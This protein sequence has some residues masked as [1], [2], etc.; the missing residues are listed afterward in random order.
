MNGA[1][2]YSF[3]NNGY[4]VSNGSAVTISG[5]SIL[6]KVSF[7]IQLVN[8]SPVN[9]KYRLHI[10]VTSGNALFSL[11]NFRLTG[12]EKVISVDGKSDL[13]REYLYEK[14][15]TITVNN[16]TVEAVTFNY[17]GIKNY[18]SQWVA[19]D[20]SESEQTEQVQVEIEMPTSVTNDL[21]QSDLFSQSV[22]IAFT[23]EAVTGNSTTSAEY[24]EWYQSDG[25]NKID[26]VAS[27]DD[28]Y[29]KTVVGANNSRTAYTEVIIPCAIYNVDKGKYLP[30]TTI[31]NTTF[32]YSE[33]R[34]EWWATNL[35]TIVVPASLKD[36]A[37]AKF[38]HCTSLKNI[39]ISDLNKNF[40]MDNG[41][42]FNTLINP[43]T[44]YCYLPTKTDTSYV[45][46]D[47]ITKV[48]SAAFGSNQY[49]TSI[50]LGSNVT[51]I[52]YGAF[53]EI[54]TLEEF[55]IPSDSQ[56]TQILSYCFSGDE[57][58]KEFSMPNTVTTLQ[59]NAF[60]GC[61]ALESIILSS[62]LTQLLDD[63]FSGCAS[64][65]SIYF[66]NTNEIS[67]TTETSKIT[68]IGNS[69]F[70]NCTSL[71]NITIP[72]K[73]TSI[74][75]VVFAN[76]QELTKVTFQGEV[77]TIGGYAFKNCY[78][79]AN[80]TIP[81]TVS[82][83]NEYTF[84]SCKSLTNITIP[85]KVTSI[86]TYAFK[87]CTGLTEIAIPA[88]VTSIGKDAF[89]SCS[90]LEYIYY[91]G[92]ESAWKEAVKGIDKDSIEQINYANV[93]TNCIVYVDYKSE[94]IKGTPYK[95]DTENGWVAVTT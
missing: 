56:L 18:Y 80:I 62:G 78:K 36:F 9:L 24:T 65:K 93:P 84:E 38:I 92:D 54:K 6:D 70:E 47:T 58:L 42:M 68:K 28:T 67:N 4:A 32:G 61:A 49:L 52:S 5:M 25:V 50:T 40:V 74:G 3:G 27:T 44:L 89:N 46:P 7:P 20:G 82:V 22:K 35:I 76:C 57:K 75:R 34:E 51:S 83:I 88:S 13:I 37:E 87:N 43:T 94:D 30:V 31:T 1:K 77:T 72:E 19:W 14:A 55:I 53:R 86:G 63:T 23:V 8:S 2:G 41:V 48:D 81:E 95:Y 17:Q 39:I 45:I 16:E 10:E 21:L 33:G 85:D 26:Y 11:L 69:V 90:K 12:K 59:R 15:S 66:S 71:T 64:L 29:Y 79:L 91:S 60:S 73:V